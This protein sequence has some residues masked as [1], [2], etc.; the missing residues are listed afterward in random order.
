V[1]RVHR[2]LSEEDIDRIAGAYHAWRGEKGAG[3]YAD[4]AGFSDSATADEIAGHDFILT[5]GRYVGAEE[6]QDD[7]EQFE[8]K[9]KRLT[10]ILR[11][12]FHESTRLEKTIRANLKGLGFEI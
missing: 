6:Q 11:E 4:R 8:D 3:K 9:M 2:E 1:D 7:G 10:A 5:P 12:Q